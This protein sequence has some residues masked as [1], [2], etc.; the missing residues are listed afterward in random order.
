VAESSL[1]QRYLVELAA[2]LPAPIVAEL[3]DGLH[4]TYLAHC[5]VGLA[6]EDAARHAVAK[7]GNPD[8]IVAAFLAT[9]PARH[10]A[11]TL[12]TGPRVGAAWA[13]AVLALHAWD[14]PVWIWVRIGLGTVLITGSRSR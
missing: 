9:N 12:L 11:R 2:K 6:E 10:A 4:E 3:A 5:V 13:T 14:W 7:F 1:I 8:A